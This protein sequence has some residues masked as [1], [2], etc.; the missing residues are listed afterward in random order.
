MIGEPWSKLD[1]WWWSVR[2]R[3]AGWF[4][5]FVC[6]WPGSK[7]NYELLQRATDFHRFE[8][9]HCGAM[10]PGDRI[11]KLRRHQRFAG[12]AWLWCP[13]CALFNQDQKTNRQIM[14]ERL[15]RERGSSK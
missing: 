13:L 7:V 15:A 14:H 12:D 1:R 9:W 11:E 6:R 5:N 2:A 3:V 8:C 10:Y 4:V